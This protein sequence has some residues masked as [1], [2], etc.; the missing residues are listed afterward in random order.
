MLNTIRHYEMSNSVNSILNTQFILFR[1]DEHLSCHR[2]SSGI[3][4]AAAS[5]VVKDY[6]VSGD[7]PHVEPI[8]IKMTEELQ[9][10]LQVWFTNLQHRESLTCFMFYV[11]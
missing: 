2:G 10:L 9:P 7:L 3:L 8:I 6:A 5:L 4:T 1:Q 11:V